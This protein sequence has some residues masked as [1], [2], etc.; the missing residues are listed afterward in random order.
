[1]KEREKWLKKGKRHKS[2]GIVAEGKR[3][4]VKIR[5][6]KEAEENGDKESALQLLSVFSACRAALRLNNSTV[7]RVL[8]ASPSL[9]PRRYKALPNNSVRLRSLTVGHNT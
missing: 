7:G 4:H 5:Y 3:T 9:F 2:K 1:M 6:R 8:P